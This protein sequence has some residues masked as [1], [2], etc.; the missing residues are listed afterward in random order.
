[1]QLRPRVR[2]LIRKAER[3]GVLVK[4]ARYDD[5]FVRGMVAIFNETPVRQGRRF[6]HYGKDFETVKRQFSRFLYREELI[7]A[8]LDGEMVGFMML[9]DAGRF[10]LTGQLL[11]SIRH[12]DKAISNALIASAVKSCTVREIPWLAYFYWSDDSL[13]EFKRRCGFEKMRVPRYYVPLTRI[14][15]LALRVRAHR[16]LRNMLPRQ[17]RRTLKQ[18]AAHWYVKAAPAAN[19]SSEPTAKG[20]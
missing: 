13:A 19:R 4:P 2:T 1:M 18:L 10:A 9:G 20:D 15:E 3:D 5:D 7:G 11:S 6:W 17:A 8:Y 14:G 12:R 16:G